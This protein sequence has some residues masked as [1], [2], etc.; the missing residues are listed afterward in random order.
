MYESSVKDTLI[1]LVDIV[2]GNYTGNYIIDDDAY[3]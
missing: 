3:L 1:N 2:L